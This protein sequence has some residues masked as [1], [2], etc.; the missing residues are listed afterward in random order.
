MK[1]IKLENGC[2][3]EI[4]Y[5]DAEETKIKSERY[6]NRRYEFNR[7]NG[8]AIIYYYEHIKIRTKEYFINGKRYLKEE[9]YKQLEVIKIKNINRNLKLLNKK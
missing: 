9:F 2:Y 4:H 1:K 5:W 3:K 8:P 7:L 6:Y